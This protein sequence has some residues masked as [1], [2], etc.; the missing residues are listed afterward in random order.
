MS[1]RLERQLLES[2]RDLA[3]EL[4]EAHGNLFCLIWDL[5]ETQLSEKQHALILGAEVRLRASQ[6]KFLAEYGEE[7]GG[8]A[9]ERN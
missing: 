4:A 9:P 8:A 7:M 3:A 5:R 6:S 1:T 2:A